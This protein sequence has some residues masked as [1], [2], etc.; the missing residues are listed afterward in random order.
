MSNKKG[1]TEAIEPL[2]SAIDLVSGK[3]TK[4][5]LTF[6][7][8]Q[9]YAKTNNGSLATENFQKVIRMRPP[10][11]VEFYARINIAGV[12]DVN[13]MDP[14]KMKKE[15]EKMLRDTKNVDFQD[16]IY[17]ALGNMA[18]K[19]GK[20]EEALEYYHKSATAISQNQNQ[21]GRS[22]LALATYYFDKPDFIKSGMYYDST[23]YFLD[24]AFPEYKEIQEKSQNLNAL[25]SQLNI[26]QREDSLQKIARMNESQRNVLI[27]SL[28]A[29]ATKEETD[30]KATD[31]TDRYNLGQFYE[32]ERRSQG[33]Y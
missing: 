8:A 4:Y 3:R 7:L 24:P 10:Y 22:F 6:L 18:M 26:I 21:R 5:R 13:S 1:I 12:F 31:Y 25:V 15:L 17:Y 27:S 32:N 30:R 23:V 28:I 2:I 9:L 33:T 29:Q 14:A 11:D 19:E 20:E 16:Q